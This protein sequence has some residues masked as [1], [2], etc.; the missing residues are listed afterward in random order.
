M[1]DGA[2]FLR[3]FLSWECINLILSNSSSR[4]K[5]NSF[6]GKF[7]VLCAEPP[8]GGGNDPLDS[9]SLSPLFS[10][11]V[12]N[13]VKTVVNAGEHSGN[14]SISS[15]IGSSECPSLDI[16]DKCIYLTGTGS[17]RL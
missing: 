17:E 9:L 6:R 8:S 3:G 14:F 7:G 11:R 4:A 16:R 10:S 12:T 2:F 13:S 15:S 1:L 5:R